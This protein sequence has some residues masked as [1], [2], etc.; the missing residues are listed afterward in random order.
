MSNFAS[1]IFS[2]S[3]PRSLL[4]KDSTSASS[5]FAG[6]GAFALLFAIL[7]TL[8]EGHI[9]GA[10]NQCLV[11]L[12]IYEEDRQIST[13]ISLSKCH[14]NILAWPFAFFNKA[15]FWQVTERLF[16]LIG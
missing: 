15:N 8:L 13:G 3:S 1:D 4:S 7:F 5:E 10:Q 11:R 14:I 16:Y 9:P 6:P 12:F 2:Q